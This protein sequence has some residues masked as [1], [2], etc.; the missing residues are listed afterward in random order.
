MKLTKMIKQANLGIVLHMIKLYYVARCLFVGKRPTHVFYFS[1]KQKEIS[2]EIWL[3][4]GM[5][6]RNTVMFKD[7][8]YTE[9]REFK[10][11]WPNWDDAKIIGIGSYDDVY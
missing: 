1:S 8:E 5:N 10:D 4:N 7:K 2:D 3:Y 9:M 6:Q 11:G